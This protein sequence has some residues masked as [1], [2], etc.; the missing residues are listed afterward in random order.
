MSYEVNHENDL[1]I[2]NRYISYDSLYF[3]G[4]NLFISN[5]NLLQN[6][7]VKRFFFFCSFSCCNCSSYATQSL[8][9]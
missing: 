3:L 7:N 1:N 5:K 8:F 9:I 6:S 2:G 4:N